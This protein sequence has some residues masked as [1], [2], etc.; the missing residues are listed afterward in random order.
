MTR[1][2]VLAAALS[3]LIAAPAQAALPKPVKYQNCA[4]LNAVYQHGVAKAGATDKVSR[5]KPVTT[6]LVYPDTYRKNTHLDR[7]KDGVACEKK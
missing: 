2:L 5:G 3:A 4:A 7:D 6:F 1:T